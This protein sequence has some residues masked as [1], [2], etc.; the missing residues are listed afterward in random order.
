MFKP[1]VL[2]FTLLAVAGLF[3]WLDASDRLTPLFAQAPAGPSTSGTPKGSPQD[4][5]DRSILPIPEPVFRGEIGITPRESTK[6]FPR[7]VKPP[8]GA[9]NVVIIMPDDVGFAASD[10]FGGPIPTPAFERVAKAG[11]TFNRFHTTAQCSPTRAALITGRNHHTCGTGAIMEMGIGYPGYNTV[12]SKK[13]AGMGD[14]LKYNGYNTAWFGKNH[15]VPDWQ[16]SQAGP[17][18]LW[19][20]GLGFEYFYGFIGGDTSM[21]EPALYEGTKPIEPPHDVADYHFDE[22]LADKA[23]ERLQML[24]VVAPEKPFFFY[25]V[26]G[27]A[28][29]PHHAPKEWINKFKGKFDQ[30][31]DKLREDTFARQ[32]K[33][34][35]IPQDAQLTNRPDAIAAWDSLDPER[36]KV[37]ARQME[38]FAGALAHCDHQINR[39]LDA[40][41]ET[42]RMDNTIVIYIMGDNGA[43]GEGNAQ[44]M[45]NEMTLFNG[46]IEDF[47]D[48]KKQVD[49]LGGPMYFNHKPAGWAH[50]T[51]T[52]FQWTKLVASHFGGTRN[53]MAISWPNRIKAK[54]EIRSQFH[55]VIDVLPTV[56]EAAN[57]PAPVKVNG[58]DQK[59]IEGTSM[60][61]TFDEAKADGRRRT[62]YFE[63]FGRRGIYHDGWVAATTPKTAPWLPSTPSKNANTDYNWELYNVDEDFSQATNLAA[64]FPDK[65]QAMKDRFLVEATKYNVLPL[66][67]SNI[68][69]FAVSN[70]PS[71]TQG[72]TTFTYGAGMTRISEGNSPD[73]KN[74][75][76]QI[77]ADLTVPENGEADGMMFT[78]GGRFNGV[79]LYVH[80]G[81]P[82]FLYNFLNMERTRVAA[83]D[84]LKP[85]KHTVVV[86]FDFLGGKQWGGPAD[87]TLL[88][89]GQEAAKA[90]IEKTIPLRIS[91]DETMDIGED[92]GTP[93][94]E[95]YKVPFK[96]KGTLG[97][98]VV[99][100]K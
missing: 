86:K 93:V 74:C 44:G 78:Q 56:L 76:W 50:A 26:P 42:G 46:V 6:D 29:A 39:F 51:S 84:A 97:K 58:V 37:F 100:L 11:L 23:I 25:Y 79:G 60:V 14:I 98:V 94:S 31:W 9:P 43:S 72:R 99:E 2:K 3:G 33:M 53:G 65:L 36:K 87:A 13:L 49:G 66:D 62:Q 89:D 34:G 82:V 90:R 4:D 10:V 12:L 54:G 35:I 1:K 19:P 85:G 95:E 16:N 40:L 81:K 77:S 32:K 80:E 22:D 18:D 27:T 28:H 63:I 21:W 48:V 61:Y 7:D 17:F 55:H 52:P 68:E 47:D 24:N 38:V 8:Q 91:L 20:T 83:K 71:L 5:F 70:R 15:N 88:I 57:I 69:R 73:L 59:P 92:A 96:F 64:K 30:G 75:S 67:D 45:L 41:E